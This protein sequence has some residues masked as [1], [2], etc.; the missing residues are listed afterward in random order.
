MFY[1]GLWEMTVYSI[2]PAACSLFKQKY[3][4][5]ELKPPLQRILLQLYLIA[6]A[7]ASLKKTHSKPKIG[8]DTYLFCHR[9]HGMYVQF[10]LQVVGNVQPSHLGNHQLQG[11]TFPQ[12]SM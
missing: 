12:Q 10:L 2:H 7:K 5:E 11:Q 4:I 6:T 9:I 8:K 3:L 1:E